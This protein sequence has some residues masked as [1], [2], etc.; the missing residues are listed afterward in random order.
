[1]RK[2]LNLF[3]I[4]LCLSG[5][6]QEAAVPTQ[7]APLY[8]Y[9]TQVDVTCRQADQVLHKQYIQDEKIESVLHYLRLLYDHGDIETLPADADQTDYEIIL[10]FSDGGRR[11]YHQRGSAYLSQD[12]GPWLI[13]EQWQGRKLL[14]L[15]R[16]MPSDV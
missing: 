16:L 7:T 4:V 1:M 6:R 14:T 13:L 9:V 5:C 11:V 15:F 2:I 12:G 8:R 3:L 10:S